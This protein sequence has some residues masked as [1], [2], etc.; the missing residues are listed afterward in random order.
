[1]TA[2]LTHLLAAQIGA[3]LGVLVMAMFQVRK[4]LN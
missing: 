4:E 2:V 3:I 1:M